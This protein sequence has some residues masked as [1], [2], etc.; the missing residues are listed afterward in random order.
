MCLLEELGAPEM[1]EESSCGT[2]PAAAGPKEE[3]EGVMGRLSYSIMALFQEMT[4][5]GSS[6][7]VVGQLSTDAR[8]SLLLF[9][10][11][12]LLLREVCLLD[13]SRGMHLDA[14]LDFLPTQVSDTDRGRTLGSASWFGQIAVF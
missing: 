4:E 8:Y 11:D 3:K 14:A 10:V 1:L 5:V 6:I 7:V 13:S 9:R 12:L 2:T